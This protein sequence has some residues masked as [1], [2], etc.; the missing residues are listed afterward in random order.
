MPE[1]RQFIGCELPTFGPR[2]AAYNSK[3]SL[4][5]QSN[6]GAYYSDTNTK[7]FGY[8]IAGRN[9]GKATGTVFIQKTF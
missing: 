5:A 9:I 7:D 3:N 4:R 8:T 2:S 1:A 6:V